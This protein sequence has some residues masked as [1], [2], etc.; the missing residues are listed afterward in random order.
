MG[1]RKK[2]APKAKEPVRI[3]FKQLKDGN[4]SIYF[5]IYRNGKRTYDFPKLYIVPEKT[6][7]DKGKNR[8]TLVRATLIK[9]EMIKEIET[10]ETGFTVN[11]LKQKA[12]FIDYIK[13][14]AAKKQEEYDKRQVNSRKGYA[15]QKIYQHHM[16]LIRH[17]TSYR[18]DKITF[19]HITKNYCS[20]FNEYLK[21]A[22]NGTY[23]RGVSE[24][25]PSG[26]LSAGSQCEYSRLL[27]VVLN[28]A[29]QEEIIA[30]NPMKTLT[31]FERPKLPES[32]REYLTQE[33][34]MK[35]AQTPC[36]K[37]MVKQA[38]LFTCFSGLR[39]SD[40]KALQWGDFLID[41]DGKK[42][43][44]YTQQKT[45]K[46]EYLQ[47]SNE[48]LQ[49]LPDRTDAKDSDTIFKLP[50]NGYTNQ[51]LQSWVLAAGIKKRV[52][53]HVGRHTNATLLLSL[54]IPIETV[55][56]MLGHSEIKTT[57]IYAKVIDKNKREA[58]DKLGSI[59]SGVNISI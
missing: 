36:V 54:G 11:S 25:Y 56:K 43:I 58:A 2:A 29:V 48:A 1:N 23:K 15:K 32:N 33:E 7:A 52:S 51:A 37:P 45:K 27:S 3:R 31:R 28:C 17:L 46:H 44:R 14:L 49:F 50:N 4:Q 12:N 55:S 19:K 39:F 53:F 22:E 21:T 10:N 9:N 59:L 30:S 41:N 6:E 34:V 26:L 57:Q 5:D 24:I 47:V 8:E 38:F 16:G 42:V 13:A 40:V 18:G 35:L 20:G